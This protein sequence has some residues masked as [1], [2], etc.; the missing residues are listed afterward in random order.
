[1]VKLRKSQESSILFETPPPHQCSEHAHDCT[2]TIDT[3]M[4]YTYI[5]IHL[6]SLYNQIFFHR[7]PQ[8]Q[9]GLSLPRIKIGKYCRVRTRN[10]TRSEKLNSILII[11]SFSA[12]DKFISRISTQLNL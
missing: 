6:Y 10:R 3:F 12:Y 11:T 9:G 2:C 5:I 8:V 1:M 4:F 7:T